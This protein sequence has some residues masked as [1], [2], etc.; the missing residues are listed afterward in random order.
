MRMADRALRA[1]AEERLNRLL[2]DEDGIIFGRIDDVEGKHWHVGLNKIADG[3]ELLVISFESDVGG[4]FADAS[5][6]EP[7][8]LWRRRRFVVV[9]GKTVI[10]LRDELLDG[11]DP[12]PGLVSDAILEA[13]EEERSGEMR[14]IAA[15]IERR[16][17]R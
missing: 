10:S 17:T 15:T 14:H 7:H 13:L 11:S 1:L 3:T 5:P 4:K 12:A 16:R 6:D 8:G 2:D 9:N